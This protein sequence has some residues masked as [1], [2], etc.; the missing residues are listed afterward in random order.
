M[1]S[2]INV[3]P[4]P[5]HADTWDTCVILAVHA[6]VAHM[7]SMNGTGDRAA[8][9]AAEVKRE[10]IVLSATDWDAFH[11]ALLNPPEPNAALK[12]AALNYRRRAGE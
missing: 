4:N 3:A 6:E 10:R 8:A 1:V 12:R 11:G 5:K 7:S 2:K 9:D